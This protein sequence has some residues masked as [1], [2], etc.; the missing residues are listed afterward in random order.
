MRNI[1]RDMKE[2]LL[3]QIEELHG[4][5]RTNV[6][7]V[8]QVSEHI[9]DALSN[10]PKLNRIYVLGEVT[11]ASEKQGHVYF[12]IKDEESLLQCIL[13]AGN[14]RNLSFKIENG[15]EILVFGSIN[16]YKKR[17][18]YQLNVFAV[19]PV[20]EGAFYL[21]FKQLKEKLSKEGLF[22]DKHKKEIPTLPETIGLITSKTSAA[23]KDIL[24]ILKNRFPNITI[25][26]IDTLT[27]G[28]KASQEIINAIKTMNHIKS[29]DVII[30]A[31]GG[32]SIEDLMCFNDEQ[33]AHAIYAS[34]IP[35]ITGV[36][37]E[38]D[39]TIADFV[40]DKRAATPSIAAKFAVPNKKDLIDEVNSVGNELKKSY[41]NFITSKL[42]DKKLKRYKMAV[43]GLIIL[44][45]I[46][47]A[48][49]LLNWF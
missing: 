3:E 36:G 21:Q 48:M 26:L 27:Q 22:D 6:L 17:G 10:D 11:N 46:F 23:C 1:V 38:T 40:A 15:L 20:G 39:Y 33:L 5:S 28:S 25:K 41:D 24:Q 18:I 2:E 8:S 7:T 31:R 14:N 44:I 29:I 9:H 32:G 47:T 34:N 43:I 13:F 30:L 16:T 35:I 12:D 37:H 45:L 19:F 4:I 42:K 49:K